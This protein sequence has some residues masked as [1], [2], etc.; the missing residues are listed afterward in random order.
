MNISTD[1]PRF[2]LGLKLRRLRKQRQLTL[3][4]LA[5]K[6]GMAISYLSEI[7][8]GKKYPK[9]E[10]L[11]VMAEALEIS[12]DELVSLKVSDDLVSLKSALGSP[13]LREFPF[14]LFGFDVEDVFSLFSGDPKRAGALMRALVDVAQSHDLD[15]ESFLLAALRAY[16][17]MH[18]NHFPDL[19]S[20]AASFRAETKL[21]PGKPITP[22]PLADSLNERFGYVLDF[23]ALGSNQELSGFRSVFQP[24]KRPTLFI[25][26]SLLPSQQAFVLAREVGYAVL[27]LKERALTSSW[28]QVESFDQVLNNFQASYFS[29]ALLLDAET[30]IDDISKI[31]AAATWQPKLLRQ[32]MQRFSATPETYFTR[33]TQVVPKAFNLEQSYFV[34]MSTGLAGFARVTKLLNMSPLSLTQGLG[35]QEHHCRR[36]P[37]FQLLASTPPV[38]TPQLQAQRCHFF[39]PDLDFLTLSAS[40]PFALD[41]SRQSSVTIG[42]LLNAA[43]RRAIRF[44]EDP[45]IIQSEVGFTCERCTL[46]EKQCE[47][48]VAP[49]DKVDALRERERREQALA[50]LDAL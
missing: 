18:H 21:K 31:F 24:R 45:A 30:V 35:L 48:R 20:A 9:P 2:V 34:R 46:T 36:W 26:P 15:F 13:F 14:E 17:Q 39:E 43:T 49:A 23:E 42:W 29:G 50:S 22:Q 25:N 38:A 47:Q 10:K 44:A 4:S 27:G 8:K 5:D 37:S 40:R 32:A 41:A 16:Q 19:E 11:M 12:F 7:E 3:S 28:L 6:T 33:L 1:N